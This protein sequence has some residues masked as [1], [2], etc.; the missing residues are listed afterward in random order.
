MSTNGGIPASG[1]GGDQPLWKQ[2]SQ[3]RGRLDTRLRCQVVVVGGGLAGLSTA[4][5]LTELDP[6]RDIV[7]L[8][9]DRVAAGASGRGTGLLGP[10]V[11]PPL[12]VAR[13]R[14]GDEDTRALYQSSEHAVRHVI[15]LCARHS[16]ACDLTR[17]TQLTV[18]A[19]AES[20]RAMELELEAA[21]ALQL[22]IEEVPASALPTRPG[23]YRGGLRYPFAA[24][25]DP[26]ALTTALARLAEQ[27]GVRIFERSAVRRVEY[28][29]PTRAHTEHGEVTADRVVLTLNGFAAGLG[30]TGVVGMRAQAAATHPL[31]DDELARVGWLGNHSLIELGQL[32]PYYR[33]T[34]DGR[35]I[36]GGGA[37]RRGVHGSSVIDRGYLAAALGLLHPSLVGLQ[38]SHA[39]SGPIGMTLDSVP[40]IGSPNE[41]T[42][43]AAGWCGHGVAMATYAGLLVAERIVT[44]EPHD[45]ALWWRRRARSVPTSGPGGRALD[46]YLARRTEAQANSLGNRVFRQFAATK[47][48]RA[49]GRINTRR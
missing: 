41:H 28:G 14:Y 6:N 39:W 19:D 20:E 47:A 48:A 25:L 27:R 7:V 36:V 18:A 30:P 11:G 37:V 31:T 17:A 23:Q 10:R 13:R 2:P 35:V 22:G 38:F 15:D 29:T 26:A 4:L 44:G 21:Q 49:A 45:V 3:S 32:A 24:T 46:W 16:I 12:S 42:L 43:V 8:E 33:L 5:H 1:A 9:A 34:V 40:V